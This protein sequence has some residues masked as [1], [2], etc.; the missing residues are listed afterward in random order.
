M[1]TVNS[2]VGATVV[3]TAVVGADVGIA[4]YTRVRKCFDID[5]K[6]SRPRSI[7]RS[8]G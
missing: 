1:H 2:I 3:G 6:P 7:A 4:A 8:T 5:Q